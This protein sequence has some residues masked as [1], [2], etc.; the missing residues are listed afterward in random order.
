MAA[1]RQHKSQS[2][3]TTEQG[4]RPRCFLQQLGSYPSLYTYAAAASGVKQ[5]ARARCIAAA[6]AQPAR[7]LVA[8]PTFFARLWYGSVGGRLFL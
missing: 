2:V 1:F 4:Y 5:P 7:R 3:C 6:P 8:V